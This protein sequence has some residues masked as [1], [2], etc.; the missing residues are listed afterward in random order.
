M[1]R[2][3]TSRDIALVI[4]GGLLAGAAVFTACAGLPA[5]ISAVCG[6]AGGFLLRPAG[7]FWS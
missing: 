1:G 6:L 5:W 2:N 4:L 7:W 3:V